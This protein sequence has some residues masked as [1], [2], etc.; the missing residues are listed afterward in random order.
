MCYIVLPI[1]AKDFFR[2]EKRK[3]KMFN[4]IETEIP[5]GVNISRNKG[6]DYNQF[7]S[8]SGDKKLNK[9]VSGRLYIQLG[10]LGSGNHFIEIGENRLGF[11][12]LTIHSGS[13]NPGYS[14]ASHYMKLAKQV[15]KDLPRE[16]LHLNGEYG[17]QYLQDLNF[18]LAYALRNR[19]IMMKEVL[20][21]FI[22][23]PVERRKIMSTMVNE[24]HNH[25]IVNGNEVLHRKG[26]TPAEKGQLGVIPGSMGTGTYLTEGLGNEEFLVSSSHGAGRKMSRKKAKASITMDRFRETM[27]GIVARIDNTMLDEAPDAYKNIKTVIKAQDGIVIKEI[28]FSKPLIVIKG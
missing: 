25:A 8:A 23:T 21:Y 14:I 15:D 17:Q 4:K 28:D 20:E 1:L 9:K 11:I 10:T 2:T 3:I 24:N 22:P 7:K 19:E 18:A 26:A 12:T 6:I 13:R 5:M 27:K 16:F